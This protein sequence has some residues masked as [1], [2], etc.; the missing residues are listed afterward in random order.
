MLSDHH[1]FVE[2]YEEIRGTSALPLLYDRPVLVNN[3]YYIDGGVADNLPLDIAIRLKCTDIVV[4]M[5]QQIKSYKF[6]RRHTRLVN[7]LVKKFAKNQSKAV[8]KILPTNEKL[9]QLNLRRLKHPT[10]K[11]RIYVL[12]PSDEEF[13]ISLASI[14]KPKVEKLGKLGV[15]D[16]DSFLQSSTK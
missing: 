15:T 14:D 3:R 2:I 1:K 12:E 16:M 7:H 6:D 5:T 4:V 10:K 13:L 9:L 11:V 8:R